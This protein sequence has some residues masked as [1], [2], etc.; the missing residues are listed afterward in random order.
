MHTTPLKTAPLK[1]APLKTTTGQPWSEWADSMALRLA[2]RAQQAE[3][4][5]SLPEDTVREATEAGF[6][7]MLAPRGAGG[8]GATFADFMDVVRRLS[9]GCTSSAW[10]LSFLAL[11][12]WML[13]KFGAEAQADFF[14]DGAMPLAPA[15]LAP[16]GKAERTE[17]GFRVNGRWEWATGINHADWVLVNAIDTETMIPRFCAL[18]VADVTVEKVWHVS[19]MVATGSHA[20]VVRDVVVPEYRTLPAMQMAAG[21]SPG[22]AL[23]PGST[24]A[25]PMRAA[26]ALVAA[27]PALGA[28]DSS[29]AWFTNRMKTKLQ[30]FSGGARQVEVQSTHLR[31]GEAMALANAARLLWEDTVARLEEIGPDGASAPTETVVQMRLACAQIVRLAQQAVDTLGASA[32]ASSGFLSVPLQRNLRDLQMMRGHVVFDWDRTASLAGRVALGLPT[33]PADLL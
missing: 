32:G 16:T 10:T 12:A 28:A 2:E 15:P 29:I 27:T 24:L 25:Y 4:I 20:V 22:E 23:H 31:L 19:G 13:A 3:E 11:H 26:L 33:T 1:T 18:P 21:A 6:F 14:R 17:G 9:N 5:R 7:A 8:Q 30:A